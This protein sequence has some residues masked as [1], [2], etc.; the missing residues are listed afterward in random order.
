MNSYKTTI[1]TLVKGLTNK[2]IQPYLYVF[3]DIR[4][5]VEHKNSRVDGVGPFSANIMTHFD[6]YTMEDKLLYAHATYIIFRYYHDRL[7]G[8]NYVISFDKHEFSKMIKYNKFYQ[9]T[10]Y[11][12]YADNLYTKS[13]YWKSA[14][15]NEIVRRTST[16]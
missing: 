11:K 16:N 5:A 2:T 10:E 15:P 6:D 4:K 12:G 9:T 1:T 14:K 8:H 3:E 13:S 7:K